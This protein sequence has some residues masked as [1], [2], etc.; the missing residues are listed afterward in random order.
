MRRQRGYAVSGVSDNLTEDMQNLF[1]G[2]D[3]SSLEEAQAEIDQL[4]NNRNVAPVE[5]FHGLSPNQMYSFLNRPFDSPE[6]VKF[7]ERLPPDLSVPFIDLLALLVETIGGQGL[8][9]TATGNLPPKFC[10]AAALSYW[11][12][13]RYSSEIRFRSIRTEPDFYEIHCLR[14]LA[15]LCG[16]VRK[17]KGKYIIGTK[18]RK[19]LATEGTAA[20]YPLL[21]K[22]Y[23]TEF[24]WGYGDGYE[25]LTFIQESF[26]FSLYLLHKYGDVERPQT[27]YQ[28]QFIKA[29][30]DI[31]H[32]VKETSY[33]TPEEQVTSM[34]FLRTF[35]CFLNY[36]GL[37][38]VRAQEKGKVLGA[39]TVKKLPLLDDVVQFYV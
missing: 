14:V 21:I 3:F 20:L 17:Y 4:L 36:F 2:N 6:L 32:E 31:V 30:P 15:E 39:Y 27:F 10:K 23:I 19:I 1:A 28:K 11:G 35:R 16:I 25:D 37:A 26:L 18:F 12:E 9:A 38:E 8:K 24:N 22:T 5:E 34:Y 29:F 33:S 13:E 7:S